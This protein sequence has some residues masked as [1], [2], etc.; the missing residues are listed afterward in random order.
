MSRVDVALFI[1]NQINRLVKS[2]PEIVPSKAASE[3]SDFTVEAA[4]NETSIVEEAKA[5]AT[6]K[7]VCPRTFIIEA[8]ELQKRCYE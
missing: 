8:R 4:G 1:G 6:R 3:I 7:H 2:P 5:L